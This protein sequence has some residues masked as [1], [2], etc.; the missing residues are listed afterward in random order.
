MERPAW[1]R[2]NCKVGLVFLVRCHLKVFEGLRFPGKMFCVLLLMYFNCDDS[3]F[4]MCKEFKDY[5]IREANDISLTACRIEILMGAVLVP[6]A[7]LMSD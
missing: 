4:K 5:R 6:M 1:K 3:S 2:K 7:K